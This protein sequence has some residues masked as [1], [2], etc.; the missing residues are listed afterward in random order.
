[1]EPCAA[2][3]HR[4]MMDHDRLHDYGQRLDALCAIKTPEGSRAFYRLDC[5]FH[6]YMID[7]ADNGILTALFHNLMQQSYRAI[8]FCLMQ[9]PEDS[10]HTLPAPALADDICH[11]GGRQSA[12]LRAFTAHINHSKIVAQNALRKLRV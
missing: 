11:Y 1:M 4:H 10:R 7:C 12:I 5:E 8:M 9:N 2:A 6:Q 3:Q